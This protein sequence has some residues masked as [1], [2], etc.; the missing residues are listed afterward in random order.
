MMNLNPI[1][2][3]AITRHDMADREQYAAAQRV[4]RIAR[5]DP[6]MGSPLLVNLGRHLVSVGMR[7]QERYHECADLIDT[8]AAPFTAAR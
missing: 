8:S 7:M 4:A 5:A 3:H 1:T 6:V 2:A